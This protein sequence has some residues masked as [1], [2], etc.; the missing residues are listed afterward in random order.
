[1]S[2]LFGGH[3]GAILSSDGRYRYRLD[4]P[5]E[6]DG[7]VVAWFGVNPSIADANLEDQT[8]RKW[9]GFSRIVGARKYIAANPFAFRATD[10]ADLARAHDRGID[11]VGPQNAAHLEGIIVDADLLIPCWG[12]RT[13]VPKALRYHL[14]ELAAQLFDSGKPLKVLGL[15]ASGDPK[16][17]LTLGYDTP[18]V[19]WRRSWRG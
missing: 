15:T 19:A 18:I 1:M 14:D 11:V 8:T 10:I 4:R 13:K 12:S 16:H 17:P 2:D 9:R 7:P 3:G 6:G 5:L